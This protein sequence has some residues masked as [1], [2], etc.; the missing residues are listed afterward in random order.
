MKPGRAL[1]AAAV[2]RRGRSVWMA[3]LLAAVMTAT[4]VPMAAAA[5]GADAA[6]PEC[7]GWLGNPV[8]GSAA[9]NAAD[10][11]NQRCAAEG[12]RILQQ[13]PAVA[14]AKTANVDVGDGAFV[15]DPFRAPNRWAGK[16]GRYQRI[17][18]TDHDGNTWPAALF[19]RAT[20]RGAVSGCVA[21][22]PRVLPAPA[23]DR[24]R[25]AVVLGRRVA[26]RSRLRRAVRHRRWQQFVADDRRD[27]FPHGNA[28]IA[29]RA[30]GVQSLVQGVGP[31][32]AGDRRSLRRG[33]R[34]RSTWGT[35]IHATRRSWPGIRPPPTPS[36]A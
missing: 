6:A 18:Y 28:G 11:N 36:R 2:V 24:E 32:P 25:R 13:N 1:G 23:D 3:T 12:L 17:T 30:W 34:Q 31:Q 5:N 27:R 7:T 14:A 16:R 29:D 35:A 15:G 19:G 21:R 26:R 8:S 33:R 10:L 22:L 9:W 4:G 20:W